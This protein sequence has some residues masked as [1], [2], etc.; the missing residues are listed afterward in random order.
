MRP[1]VEEMLVGM[2]SRLPDVMVPVVLGGFG[3]LG[4]WFLDMDRFRCPICVPI[5]KITDPSLGGCAGG[6]GQHHYI[7]RV[8][9]EYT[10]LRLYHKR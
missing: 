6:M 3:F 8:D 1:L 4:P 7:V 10:A 5:R 9:G 2:V